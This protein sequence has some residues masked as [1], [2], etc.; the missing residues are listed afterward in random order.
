[1]SRNKILVYTSFCVIISVCGI[2][3]PALFGGASIPGPASVTFA[4]T[5]CSARRT[6]HVLQRVIMLATNVAALW[7]WSLFSRSRDKDTRRLLNR[8]HDKS[9]EV[10]LHRIKECTGKVASVRQCWPPYVCIVPSHYSLGLLFKDVARTCLDIML[11]RARG[12]QSVAS[13]DSRGFYAPE[14]VLTPL[15]SWEIMI[16]A[17]IPFTTICVTTQ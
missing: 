4:S 13:T 11:T 1:M 10:P 5:F 12:S 14:K 15:P 17:G 8:K 6:P 7:S 9:R 16:S 3:F 2:L